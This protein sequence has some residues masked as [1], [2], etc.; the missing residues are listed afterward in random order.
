M[1]PVLSQPNDV[2]YDRDG[3][4]IATPANAEQPIQPDLAHLPAQSVD[5]SQSAYPEAADPS[6][7]GE[8]PAAQ[9]AS[10]QEA[11]GQSSAGQM[12]AGQMSWAQ[13]PNLDTSDFDPELAPRAAAPSATDPSATDPVPA[14]G[15]DGA[16]WQQPPSRGSR[17]RAVSNWT[18]QP[19][20]EPRVLV[21][22]ME[23]S[24]WISPEGFDTQAMPAPAPEMIEIQRRSRSFEY[25][26]QIC[27]RC[28]GN[29]DWDG[30][31]EQCGAKAPS[32]RDRFDQ[33]PAGWLAGLTDLG[34]RHHRNEDAMAL[35]ADAQPGSLAIVVVCDG[36]STSTDSDVA[37]LAAAEAARGVLRQRCS[38]WEALRTLDEQVIDISETTNE[39]L[40]NVSQV[41]L[42]GISVAND[43]VLANTI[44]TQSSPPSC[45]L[46]AAL[47]RD[48]HALVASVGDS[49]AYWV[50]D[51][52]EALQLSVDDSVAQEQI[53]LGMPREEAESGPHSHVITRW[54]GH[55]APELAPH[56]TVLPPQ[57][58]A[59]YLVVCSDGLWNYASAPAEIAAI[60]RQ[61]TQDRVDDLPAACRD[62]VDWANEQGGHDNITV[63]L[64]R[65]DAK[66]ASAQTRPS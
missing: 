65:L 58:S 49:R 29:I 18:M 11:A 38:E 7:V 57:D 63:T 51:E 24:A 17:G 40:I 19:K 31:C 22:A 33:Q 28:G 15:G 37:S 47:V 41:L 46:V 55:D 3:E 13:P 61:K 27:H 12:S 35:D 5:A 54:L 1:E 30:Y 14:S 44:D 62:L 56:F 52:G 60:I 20:T 21:G 34:I 26:G 50:P 42:D 43:A 39:D 16:A 23:A 10:E 8:Q 2:S 45:T 4:P 32:R 9:V 25:A 6:S 66:K 48:G 59:G 64:T 36:V 53:A